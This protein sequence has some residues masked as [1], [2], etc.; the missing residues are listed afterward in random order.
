MRQEYCKYIFTFQN[1]YMEELACELC[2][3]FEISKEKK[4]GMKYHDEENDCY[5][6]LICD[7]DI[8]GCVFTAYPKVSYVYKVGIFI[9]P[10]HAKQIE[11]LLFRYREIILEEYGEDHLK[12]IKMRNNEDFIY[13][14]ELGKNMNFYESIK[15]FLDSK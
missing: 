10:T 3:I 15:K 1:E 12:E 2:E 4:I 14:R 6:F 13:L 7:N 8:G 11:E 5:V 9:Q